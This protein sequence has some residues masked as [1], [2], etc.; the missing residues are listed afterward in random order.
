MAAAL[1]NVE[2]VRL[3][4]EHHANVSA[5]T[6]DYSTPLLHCAR[7][8]GLPNAA[9]LIANILLD[10]GADPRTAVGECTPLYYALRR[11]LI[12][13]AERLIFLTDISS[14]VNGNINPFLL[15]ALDAF[16]FRDQR[17]A[18][19]LFLQHGC[20]SLQ[21]RDIINCV[22][23]GGLPALDAVINAQP[24]IMRPSPKDWFQAADRLKQV[25]HAALPSSKLH[26]RPS[27]ASIAILARVLLYGLDPSDLVLAVCEYED[28][29]VFEWATE[30]GAK[31]TMY[32]K[33]DLAEMI[34]YLPVNWRRM[35]LQVWDAQS[36]TTGI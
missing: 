28:K 21:E 6:E 32:P 15:A 23:I 9:L 11:P 4:C 14:T 8:C 27:S 16:R 20:S 30:R 18:L 13:L 35:V 1:G 33:E 29:E 26:R 7:F 25:V 36:V 22:E 2:L 10:H 31:L 3:L 12:P 5:L 19:D 24:P 17:A 34:R